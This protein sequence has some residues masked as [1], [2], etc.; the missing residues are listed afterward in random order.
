VDISVVICAYTEERWLAL[1]AAVESIKHQT[2]KASE[3]IVVVD[4]N[5]RLLK[6]VQESIEGVMVINNKYPR[7]LSG[8][9]NSGIDVAKGDVIAFIDDDAVAEPDWLENLKKVYNQS[10]AVGAGGLIKPIWE[11]EKPGWFPEEFYWII[12]C[13]YRGMPEVTSSIRNLIGCNMSFK[14]TIFEQVGGF[15]DG[16]GRVEKIPLGCEETELCIRIRQHSSESEIIYEPSAIVHHL[17]PQERLTL[18]YFFSRC[19]AE[20]I[21]KA[22]ISKLTGANDGLASER[23]HAFRVLPKG[24][25][26]GLRDVVIENNVQGLF[27]A[28]LIVIGLFT[29]TL[30]LLVRRLFG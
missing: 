16:I 25:V 20:G 27:R 7:G 24:V 10:E 17:V 26:N 11:T 19:F 5:E 9:R 1:V 30:G 23:R 8:A 2:F 21:S 6:R 3:I 15:Y 29:T 12:G 28:T 14:R 13:T 4:H 18:N 22:Q